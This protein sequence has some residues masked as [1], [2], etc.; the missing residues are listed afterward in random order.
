M[1]SLEQAYVFRV[2]GRC[3]MSS[4]ARILATRTALWYRAVSKSCKPVV[5]VIDALNRVAG[6]AQPVHEGV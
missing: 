3:E 5:V 1:P 2:A 6:I 4:S